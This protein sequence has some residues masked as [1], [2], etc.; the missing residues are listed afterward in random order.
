MTYSIRI[1]DPVYGRT[2]LVSPASG[3]HMRLLE[4]G[5]EGFGATELFVETDPYADGS[6]GHP[7]TRR[8]GERYLALTG[9]LNGDEGELRRLICTMMNPLETLEMEVV[10]GDVTRCI[11]VIPCGR[12]AFRQANFFTPTEVYLPFLA[13]DPFWRDAAGRQVHFRQSIPLL[14]FPLNFWKGAGTAAAYYRVTDT[15]AVTNPGDAPCGFD[16]SLTAVGG[17]VVNPAICLGEQYIRLETALTDGQTAQIDTR[18]R[19]KNLH[20]DGERAFTFHRDSDF[21][22]LQVGEN[23]VFVT[24]ESGLEHL[25]A[26]L[27]YTPLYYGI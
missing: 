4:D 12:P 15:A 10:L 13:P 2:L 14:T 7:V 1:T 9:E 26:E 16:A 20:I 3:A 27:V 18:P 23:R 11:G 17:T 6:G 8:F 5:L 25:S 21:F 22:L 24:A 19:C